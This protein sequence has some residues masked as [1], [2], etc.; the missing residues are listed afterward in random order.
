MPTPDAH[1]G[2]RRES[3]IQASIESRNECAAH[4]FFLRAFPQQSAARNLPDVFTLTG[5]M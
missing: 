2:K 1:L 4:L 5:A 3:S